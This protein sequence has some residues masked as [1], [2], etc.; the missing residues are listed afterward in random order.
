MSGLL[1]AVYQADKEAGGS[2]E[3]V[4]RS[5][6]AG[7]GRGLVCHSITFILQAVPLAR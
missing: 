1:S 2:N 7:W 6:S 4:V 3:G 5:S